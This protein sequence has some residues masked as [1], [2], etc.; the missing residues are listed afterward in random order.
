MCN[1][2]TFLTCGSAT[3]WLEHVKGSDY[4]EDRGSDVGGGGENDIKIN[5]NEI[6]YEGVHCTRVAQNSNRPRALMNQCT[7][8]KA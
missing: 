8:E 1:T 2:V 6:R 3:F 7:F 5:L 4:L